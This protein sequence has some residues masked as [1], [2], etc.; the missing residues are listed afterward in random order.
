VPGNSWQG[1][2]EGLYFI[3]LRS[4]SRP[5]FCVF[6]ESPVSGDDPYILDARN[7]LQ[8]MHKTL[9]ALPADRRRKRAEAGILKVL[10]PEV[11]PRDK[12]GSTRHRDGRWISLVTGLENIVAWLS[13]FQQGELQEATQWRVKDVSERGY[14][15]AWNESA[16]SLLQVGDLVCL[17][18]DS[19]EQT[20]QR[21]QLM[22]VRWLRDA[23]EQGTE[24]GVELIDGTPSAVR[25][26]NV[27][28]AAMETLP[29]LFMPSGGAQGSVARLIAPTQVYAENRSLLIYVG[30]REVAIRC[31]APVE[32]APGFDCFEFTGS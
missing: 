12:R 32:Q 10:L 1:V 13:A 6:L 7:A 16:A 19:G 30:E 23:R 25:V 4:D 27:E 11:T 26:K 28:E 22:V 8:R 5:R 14:C 31:G 15:L 24:L 9:V 2:P 17:V 29:A 3:D 21:L 20:P 18:S